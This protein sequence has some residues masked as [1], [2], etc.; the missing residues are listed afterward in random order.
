MT[1]PLDI[2]PAS[3]STDARGLHIT[4]PEHGTACDGTFYSWDW[5]KQHRCEKAARLARKKR[6]TEP[7]P[8]PTS[9][10]ESVSVDYAQ[11]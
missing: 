11:A 1:I 7:G 5:L 2:T 8:P 4:W 3:F 9:K 6:R 10:T